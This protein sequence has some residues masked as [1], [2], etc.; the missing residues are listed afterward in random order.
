MG[1]H[2]LICSAVAKTLERNRPTPFYKKKVTRII[3]GDESDVI[4]DVKAYELGLKEYPWWLRL[5]NW[6]FPKGI[7]E[8]SIEI[9]SLV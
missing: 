1:D 2:E 5:K 3:T 6:L 9:E 8:V 7:K 4:G